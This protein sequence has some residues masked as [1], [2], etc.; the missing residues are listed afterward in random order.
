M[1]DEP[2]P[3]P[4]WSQLRT[5]LEQLD[6][7]PSKRFG[8]NFLVE[9]DA[10]ERI[11][12]CAELLP[13]DFVLEVGVGPGLLTRHLLAAGAE[14]LG[15][16]IDH[17][18][19][20][21]AGEL[22]AGR[23]TLD[24]VRADALAGKHALAPE[25]LERLPD[26]SDWSLV[27]NLPYSIASPLM[28]LLSS[29]PAPPRSMTVLVQDEVAVRVTARPGRKEWGPLTARLGLAYTAERLFSVSRTAFR[30][31]PQVQSA[32][33]RLERM[34]PALSPET[35]ARVSRLIGRLFQQRRKQVLGVLAQ[36][37]DGDRELSGAVLES[38]GL[39]ADCRISHLTV[40]EWRTLSDALPSERHP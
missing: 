24:L 11:V 29:L 18:L 12:Q 15:I 1:T 27:A 19:A 22:L 13:E 17:R 16:E 34:E 6:F 38:A 31:K 40:A 33:V 4:R 8:Q 32:V 36:V 28:V 9:G 21:L 5:R 7:R 14:V 39:A 30:P 2:A 10:C 35:A 23:G 37:L 25:L 26:H 20:E 3:W